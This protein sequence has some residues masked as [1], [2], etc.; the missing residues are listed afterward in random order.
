MGTQFYI[1]TG[2]DTLGDSYAQSAGGMA[3][4]LTMLREFGMLTD[5]EPPERPYLAQFG[6]SRDDFDGP[7]HAGK[8]RPDKADSFAAAQQAVLDRLEGHDPATTGIPQYKVAYNEGW[9]IAPKEIEAALNAYDSSPADQR[10][11]AEN[12]FHGDWKRWIAFLREAADSG[13][14]VL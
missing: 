7:V 1:E 4:L 9:L 10:R 13:I 2:T 3:V 11:D 6:L 12:S 8:V 14:R 5:A